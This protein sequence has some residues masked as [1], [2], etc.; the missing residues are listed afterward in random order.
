MTL[1]NSVQHLCFSIN[2]Q[3]LSHKFGFNGDQRCQ[4]LKHRWEPKTHKIAFTGE[5]LH[6]FGRVALI[7]SR[8]KGVAPLR[9]VLYWQILTTFACNRCNL[10]I[11]TL[12][13]SAIRVAFCIPVS[14]WLK[15]KFGGFLKVC[16]QVWSEPTLYGTR[17]GPRLL[18]GGP[19]SLLDFIIRALWALKL[20]DP[21]R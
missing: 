3:H 4:R 10:E 5:V 16:R 8:K 2:V 20:C 12:T 19:S 6:I 15:E 21:R 13:F 17:R 9:E 1:C 18:A 14:W 7:M 11:V